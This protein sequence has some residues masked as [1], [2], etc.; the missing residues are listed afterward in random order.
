MRRN[1][2]VDPIIINIF[3]ESSHQYIPR[4]R[5]IT[6]LEQL[7]FIENVENASIN[8][9]VMDND[10]IQKINKQYLG[11]DYPTDVISFKLEEKPL[12][13]EIYISVE[14]AKNNSEEYVNSWREEI[15]RYA[16]HGALHILGYNDSTEKEIKKMRDLENKYLE[17]Q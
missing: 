9:I 1:A 4:Q 3:N 16:I 6:T 17:L 8:I 14:M 7:F 13:A 10:G 5:V 11:H 15:V 12:E 2:T